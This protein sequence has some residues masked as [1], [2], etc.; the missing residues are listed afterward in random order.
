MK[1][2]KLKADRKKAKFTYKDS[3]MRL[4]TDPSAETYKPEDIGDLYLEFLKKRNPN[5]KVVSSQT[6]LRKWERKSFSDKQI[7]EEF[8]TNR[9]ALEEVLKRVL[10]MEKKKKTITTKTHKLTDHWYHKAT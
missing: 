7:L 9:S 4:T 8:V 3:V 6:K 10:N 2:K 5:T 1:K